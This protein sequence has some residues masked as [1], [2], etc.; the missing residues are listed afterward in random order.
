[1]RKV[2]FAQAGMSL[3]HAGAFRQTLALLPDDAVR[4]LQIIEAAHES[5]R[6]GRTVE[7]GQKDS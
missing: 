1:M 2:R 3:M 7:I 6:T 5:A 4:S